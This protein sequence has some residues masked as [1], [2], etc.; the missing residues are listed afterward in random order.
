MAL[1]FF[2]FFERVPCYYSVYRNSFVEGQCHQVCYF[3]NIISAKQKFFDIT[4]PH[5]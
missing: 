3:Y 2:E 5:H 4:M 1:C